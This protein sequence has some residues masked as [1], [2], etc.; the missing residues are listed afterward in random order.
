VK[1][2]ASK[3]GDAKALAGYSPSGASPTSDDEEDLF[4]LIDAVV[5]TWRKERD[6]LRG[7][8]YEQGIPPF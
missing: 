2:G 1:T 5:S 8:K 6:L 7:I 4:G 3:Q